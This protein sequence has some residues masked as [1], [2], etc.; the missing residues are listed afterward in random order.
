VIIPFLQKRRESRRENREELARDSF[1]YD[2]GKNSND[3]IDEYLSKVDNCRN[4]KSSFFG[5][6]GV[7]NLQRALTDLFG[8]GSDTTSSLIL[9]TCMYMIKYPDIQVSFFS[10]STAENEKSTFLFV[11][12]GQSL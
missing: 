1:D 3:F 7:V 8:A 10:K 5:D 9:F 11:V 4:R 2:I 6:K 12:A